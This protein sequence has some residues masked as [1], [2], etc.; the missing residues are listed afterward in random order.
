[1]VAGERL[2]AGLRSIIVAV[3]GECPLVLKDEAG[4]QR[5]SRG[6]KNWQDLWVWGAEKEGK[7][8]V[9]ATAWVGLPFTHRENAGV[10]AR[11][12][13]ILQC[14]GATWLLSLQV[15]LASCHTGN[16]TL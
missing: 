2:G 12:E 5:C 15:Q 4:F 1:M 14:V 6:W 3:T 8:L 9:W 10:E 11:V 13:W 16:A 7:F